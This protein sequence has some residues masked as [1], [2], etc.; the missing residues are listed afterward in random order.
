MTQI[1]LIHH[2]LSALAVD[3]LGVKSEKGAISLEVAIAAAILLSAA[4]AVAA[5]IVT[6][7]GEANDQLD[8]LSGTVDLV[9]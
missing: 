1:K 5:L 8:G 4:I 2:Y 9:E 7:A 3:R 6:R